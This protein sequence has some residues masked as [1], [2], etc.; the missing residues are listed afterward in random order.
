MTTPQPLAPFPT[1]KLSRERYQRGSLTTEA[2][3]NGPKVWV[4]RWREPSDT[5]ES[6]KRKRIIGTVLEYKTETAARKAVDALRLDI[7]AEVVSSSQMTV[8][9][10]VE[11][12]REKELGEDCG[13][14]KLTR[15]VYEHNL[16]SYIL[17]RWG[18]E[19]IGDVKAFR[20][21]GW[22]KSLDKAKGTKAK[23]KSVMGVLYQHA[24]RYGW[25]ERN[26]IR[27]VR[28]KCKA[29]ARA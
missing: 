10:L 19:R 9:E 28:L 25:A 14:T 1:L 23:I 7:N 12:Y 11:H 18:A 20:I 22:L 21:E 27:E 2:R 6:V 26:P 17:P 8:G 15:E 3:S 13:K 5:G 4:Y 29:S 16:N 24:M